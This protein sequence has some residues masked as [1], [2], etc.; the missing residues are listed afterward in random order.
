MSDVAAQMSRGCY[1][2]TAPVK[3]QLMSAYYSHVTCCSGRPACKSS[4]GVGRSRMHQASVHSM[5][6]RV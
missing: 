4:G 6:V 2:E 5:S 3:F 1:E